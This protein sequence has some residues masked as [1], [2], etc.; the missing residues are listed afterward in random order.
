MPST[1]RR[2]APVV[3]TIGSAPVITPTAL[4]SATTTMWRIVGIRS[5][6]TSP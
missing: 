3:A 2:P 4:G 5:V 6:K 1:R